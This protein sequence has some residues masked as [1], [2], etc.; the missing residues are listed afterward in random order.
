MR[1]LVAA[2]EAFIL[3]G[4]FMPLVDMARAQEARPVIDWLRSFSPTVVISLDECGKESWVVGG[5]M[6]QF[7][8]YQWVHSST[9]QGV[10]ELLTENMLPSEVIFNEVL[11]VPESVCKQM[12]EAY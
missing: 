8:R 11:T 10:M 12:G 1:K 6:P 2:F 4:A 3:S 9:K 7:E 5:Y